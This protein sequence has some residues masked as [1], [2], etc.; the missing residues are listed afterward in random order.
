M[1]GYTHISDTMPKARKPYTCGLCGL[2]IQ[3]GEKHVARRSVIDGEM[4]T[5]R[6]HTKCEEVTQSWPSEYWELE[7]DTFEFRKELAEFGTKGG[8]E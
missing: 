7:I 1:T 4:R 8:K 2:S 6:M 5:A 3:A